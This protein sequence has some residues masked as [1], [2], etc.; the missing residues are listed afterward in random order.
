MITEQEQQL[1]DSLQNELRDL[2]EN[3]EK[4]NKASRKR[5][6]KNVKNS[7]NILKEYRRS[8][9]EAEKQM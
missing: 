8:S 9:L 5:A 3:H 6:R 1:L 7:I 4:G 2:L